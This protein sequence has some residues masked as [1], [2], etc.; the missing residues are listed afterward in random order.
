MILGKYNTKTWLLGQTGVQIV[1]ICL[2]TRAHNGGLINLQ[3]LCNLLR[4]RR[5]SDREAVSEDDCLRAISKLKVFWFHHNHYI[6][7]LYLGR[8]Y[9]L[10]LKLQKI[11]GGLTFLVCPLENVL[12]L[13]L[14]FLMNELKMYSSNETKTTHSK[15]QPKRTLKQLC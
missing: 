10:H 15:L 7:H 11:K 14:A 12:E 13:L 4:Q 5:K 3:E 1:E 9:M 2:A 8:E 6:H